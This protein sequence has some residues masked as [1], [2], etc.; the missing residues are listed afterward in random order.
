SF[1]TAENTPGDFPGNLKENTPVSTGNALKSEFKGGILLPVNSKEDKRELPEYRLLIDILRYP[2]SNITQR[3]KRLK[4]HSKLGNK[5]R[6]NLIFKKCVMPRK[7][8]TGKGWI[9]LFELTKKGKMVLGDMG[10]EF[11][12]KSEGVVHKFWKH[13][14]SEYYKDMGLDV[15]VEEYYI[16]GRPDIIVNKDGKKIAI[17]IET[18]KSDYV[19]NIERALA[20]GFDEV[21]CMA[22]NRFVEDKIARALKKKKIDDNRVRIVG[23]RGFGDL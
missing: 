12:N 7:I 3:Y 18:G 2:F 10:Y 11:E 14:V 22:V 6:K 13:K 17:E 16:N 19:G 9:T 20:A 5:C 1:K 23:V 21:M 8:I 15:L 4:L